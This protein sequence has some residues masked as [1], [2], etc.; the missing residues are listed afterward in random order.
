MALRLVA[1]RVSAPRVVVACRPLSTKVTTGITGYAVVP[2]A[3]EVLKRLYN[4]T[5]ESL[6]GLP[7]DAEYRK[8]VEAITNYRLKVVSGEKDA[9]GM[10]EEVGIQLEEMIQDAKDE[11]TLIPQMEEWKAWAK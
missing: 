2:D 6:K 3:P 9:D 11:L 7:Q 5:L 10:E 4:Q 1:A 8:N